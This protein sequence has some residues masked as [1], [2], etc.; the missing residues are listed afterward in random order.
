MPFKGHVD[1]ES[2]LVLPS[3][4]LGICLVPGAAEDV[5]FQGFRLGVLRIDAG[6]QADVPQ[7]II[8][9]RCDVVLALDRGSGAEAKLFDGLCNGSFVALCERGGAG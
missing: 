2:I 7:R 4:C 5:R 3:D 6:H 9:F 1:L 8:G